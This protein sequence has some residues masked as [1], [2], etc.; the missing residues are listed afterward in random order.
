MTKL[1]DEQVTEILEPVLKKVLKL[2]EYKKA[3]TH[4]D[5]DYDGDQ[6]VRVFAVL[7]K[8]IDGEAYSQAISDVNAA[9]RENGD[10]RFVHMSIG[11]P[12]KS[13]LSGRAIVQ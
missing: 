4:S 11:P 8:K 2:F 12:P 1:T 5:V 7:G 3:I 9:L 6:I 10:S 13:L